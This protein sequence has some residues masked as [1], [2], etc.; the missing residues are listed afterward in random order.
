MPVVDSS[1]LVPAFDADH[2]RHAEARGKLG[3]TSLL[4]VSGGVLA[5]VTTVLRRR[6]NDIGSDGSKV[7]REALVR[8]EELAGFRHATSYDPDEVS[9]VYQ[10]HAALSYVDAMGI[11]IAIRLDDELL[12]FDDAQ[13]KALKKE[14]RKSA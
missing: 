2:P 7:A 5:E 6:A 4:H 11:V 9:R 1:V 8:L 13:S 3:T 12:T 10:A 14:R